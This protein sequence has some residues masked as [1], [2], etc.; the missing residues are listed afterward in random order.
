MVIAGT[1]YEIRNGEKVVTEA[2]YK[3][4]FEILVGGMTAEDA[5]DFLETYQIYNP[6]ILDELEPRR[7]I[8]YLYKVRARQKERE[9]YARSVLA[10]APGNPDA[11]MVL[12]SAEPDNAIAAAG[13][14]NIVAT[15][16]ENYR[17]R[18]ALGYRLH[19]DY[20]EEAIQHLKK[21]NSFNS[22]LGFFSLGLAY[23]RLGDLKTAWLYYRKQQ[24]IE[25]GDLVVQHKRAI[26]MGRPLYEPISLTSSPT[27]EFHEVPLDIG[28]MAREE[29]FA[30]ITEETP[31]LSEFPHQERY[32]SENQPTD[33]ER[34]EAARAEFQRQQAAAQQEFDEFHKWAENIMSAEDTINLGD[35]L[36]KELA[37]H[38]SGG[39]AMFA[40]ERTIRAYEMIERYGPKEGLQ[41][42][43]EN[44]PELAEQM[45]RLIEERRPPRRNNPQNRK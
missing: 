33:Q 38:L 45:E 20:P 36:S 34:R 10:R 5:V 2:A 6:L 13:Y 7:T 8:D 25:N 24:T 40:P 32:S 12:L 44:D 29:T 27:Q 9:T 30:P 16:S 15:D 19:Y 42:L 14:R 4:N 3:R 11:Q 31:W 37:A 18:N 39:D 23:E 1:M 28:E 22:A 35:F 17:A 41:R 43:K 21:A 26:E